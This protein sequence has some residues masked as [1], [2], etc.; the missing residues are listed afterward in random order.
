MFEGVSLPF[1]IGDLMTNSTELLMVIGGII[2]IPIAMRVMDELVTIIKLV[3]NTEYTANT[4]K[5]RFKVHYGRKIDMRRARK[6]G[7]I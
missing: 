6:N 2:I 1:G 7:E 3:L 5:G 4:L